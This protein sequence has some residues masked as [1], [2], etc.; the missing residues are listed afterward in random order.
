LEEQYYIYIDD[1]DE[2]LETLAHEFTEYIITR[3]QKPLLRFINALSLLV[4][5]QAY[6]ETD[7]NAEALSKMLIDKIKSE[8]DE[9]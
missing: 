9:N 8:W 6:Q 3:P 4:R 2:A 7:K 5:E 1:P